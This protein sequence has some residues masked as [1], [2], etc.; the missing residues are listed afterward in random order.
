[1][2]APWTETAFRAL[3]GARAD[4][5]GD[6][7]SENA[8]KAEPGNGLRHALSLSM[9]KVADGLIDPK[10][11]L[12]WLLDALG[13]PDALV[14]ALVPIREAGAL[15]PQIL[16][17]GRVRR[18]RQRKWA[19]VAGSAGQGLCAGAMVL[20]ALTLSG[21]AAGLA[22]CAALAGL[23]VCRAAC[24]VSYSDILGRTVGMARRGAVTGLAGSVGSLGVLVFAGLL[25]SGMLQNR[26]AVIAAIALAALLWLAAALV[27]SGLVEDPGD[28]DGSGGILPD[29]SILRDNP[30]LW[31]FILARGLL[32]STALASPYLVLLASDAGQSALSG[33][34]AMVLASALASLL[35]SYVWGR[36]ADRSS[37]LVLM[38]AGVLG[39]AAIL[40]AV[41]LALAGL[42]DA[43]W[44]MPGA[45]FGLMIAYHG[46]R[47]GRSIYLIDMAPKDQRA[48]YTAVS[49]T[50]IGGLLLAVGLLGGLG[51]LAGPEATL[52][53]F[54]VMA[55][56]AAVVARGLDE[57]GTPG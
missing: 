28:S 53:G 47:Q 46:V 32:V 24:S 19:W 52:A 39:A 30:Q 41:A 29:L 12:S 48:T 6:G 21:V 9:T 26:G 10:L 36:L 33:L 34:G 25:I 23:A 5:D 7:L 15:L 57:F 3:T 55:L 44:A 20:A 27:F 18:L 42:A 51:S 50:V 37:R 1:M 2:P 22:I 38:R 16:M 17:A 13:A 14:G 56:L 4:R 11:V 45:L 35:S 31:R 43:V 49:N 54:A 40:A 8:R